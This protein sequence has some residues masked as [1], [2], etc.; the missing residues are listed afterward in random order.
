M[1]AEC[2]IWYDKTVWL[3]TEELDIEK[4][5][6]SLCLRSQKRIEPALAWPIPN[7]HSF[8]IVITCLHFRIMLVCV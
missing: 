2:K 6:Q 3:I 8:V 7:M 4:I 1:P 5:L